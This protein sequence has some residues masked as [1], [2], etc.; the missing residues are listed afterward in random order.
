MSATLPKPDRRLQQGFT[1]LELLLALTLLVILVGALYGSYFALFKGREA[2]SAGMESR[3][4]LRTTL[5]LLRRELSGILY[6]RNDKRFHFIVEDR[7]LYGKPASTL[8]FTA[9]APPE[10]GGSTVSDQVNI[11]YRIVEDKEKM[12][13]ARQ[14]RDLHFSAEALR[15]PQIER[16]EGFLVECRSGDKWVKSW[17]SAINMS[18]PTAVRVTVTVREDDKPVS[19][20][21]IATPRVPTW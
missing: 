2:A 4:E 17:D 3:R 6:R 11:L 13:L 15:Y 10:S 16:V 20:S 14:A 19:Y 18:L 1:L 9:I 8:S 12:I 7:D 21:I 5:D